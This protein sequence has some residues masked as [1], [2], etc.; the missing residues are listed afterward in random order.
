MKLVTELAI[1]EI[2]IIAG[3]GYVTASGTAQ[4]HA[5]EVI[6]CLDDSGHKPTE[7]LV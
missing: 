3:I 5:G 4:I 7:S 2:I 6:V 1:S